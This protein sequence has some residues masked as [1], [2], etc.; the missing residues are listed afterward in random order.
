[1]LTVGRVEIRDCQGIHR[2]EVLRVGALGFAG[3]T[4]GKLLASEEARPIRNA[5]SCILIY[6]AGGPSQFETFDPK[7]L[8]PVR[9]RGPWGAIPT[10]IPGILFGE[11]LPQLAAMADRF[12]VLRALNHS[13]ALHNPWPMLTG[14]IQQ[15]ISLGSAITHLTRQPDTKL[16][17]FVNLGPKISIG[18]G[19][20]GPPARRW[21]SRIHSSL[22][23]RCP[24]MSCRV[25]LHRKGWPTVNC[26]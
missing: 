24:I 7:P 16:P 4:L 10:R 26:C 21:R 6:L 2:R 20:S 14:N 25:T 13:N 3:L 5:K 9:I 15:R 11:M 17:A 19:R 8:A 1:M 12:A 23:H 18:A 22:M